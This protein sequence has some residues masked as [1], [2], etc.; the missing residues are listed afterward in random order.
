MKIPIYINNRNLLTSTRAMVEYLRQIP[1]AEPIIVDNAS[2]YQPLLDWYEEGQCQVIR[3]ADN[4]GPRGWCRHVD[5]SVEYY[6]ATDPDLDLS[7]VP[8]DVLSV[9]SKALDEFTSKCKVGLSLQ[10][11]DVPNQELVEIESKY[12]NHRFSEGWWDAS[13][14]TTFAMH[15]KGRGCGAYGP[16]LRADKPYTA[17]H[18]PWYWTKENIGEEELYYLEHATAGGLFYSP[19]LRGTLTETK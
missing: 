13:I 4:M 3:N 11:D 19:I 18:L 10:I 5:K 7:G 2:T 17:R 16:A 14:D 1:E 12:W 15:R 6:V 9:L 8:L